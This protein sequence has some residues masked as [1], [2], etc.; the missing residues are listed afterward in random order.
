MHK[1]A[2]RL[3]Y[4]IKMTLKKK[5]NIVDFFSFEQQ[6]QISSKLFQ[7]KHSPQELEDVLKE[8]GKVC[9]AKFNYC[10][11]IA[12]FFLCLCAH[13]FADLLVF[14]F[15]LSPNIQNLPSHVNFLGLSCF[16][17]MPKICVKQYVQC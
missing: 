4:C 14:S 9:H 11:L 6:S 5:K 10:P 8:V 7:I 13:L 12:F 1:K 17:H 3:F 2:C 16:R 15:I